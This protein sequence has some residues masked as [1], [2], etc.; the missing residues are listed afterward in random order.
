MCSRMWQCCYD[1]HQFVMW[2]ANILDTTCTPTSFSISCPLI[3]DPTPYSLLDMLDPYV[4]GYFILFRILYTLSLSLCVPV[5]R[6]TVFNF[7]NWICSSHR[8]LGL[9]IKLDWILKMDANM[10]FLWIRYLVGGNS[11]IKSSVVDPD[12]GEQKLPTK[13]EKKLINFIFWSA[14]CFLRAEGLSC[15]LEVL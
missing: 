7:F 5:P 4:F 2:K 13:I 15:S 14:G 1:L 11:M 3:R 10:L 6:G 8:S 9:R 12:P